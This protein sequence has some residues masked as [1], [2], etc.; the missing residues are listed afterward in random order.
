MGVCND[1]E[2][3]GCAAPQHQIDN[4]GQIDYV[5]FFFNGLVDP[6]QIRLNVTDSSLPDSDV[7]YYLGTFLGSPNLAGKTLAQLAG[8]GFGAVN[9]DAPAGNNGDR[10]VDL[11][12][13]SLVNAMLIGARSTS[14]NDG[15]KLKW[16]TANYTPSNDSTV[17]EPSTYLLISSGL[18]GLGLLRRRAARQ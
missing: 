10:T 1:A 2:A 3:P 17:P 11:A 16:V 13:N 14:N 18:V 5:L 4:S 15:F 6:L 8:L 7:E 12:G 9:V